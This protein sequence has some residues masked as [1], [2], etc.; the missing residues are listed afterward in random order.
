VFGPL[1]KSMEPGDGSALA[2][3]MRSALIC[4]SVAYLGDCGSLS[5]HRVD[6]L[7]MSGGS[8]RRSLRTSQHLLLRYDLL[9]GCSSIAYLSDCNSLSIHRIDGLVLSLRGCRQ[10]LYN[11]AGLVA[12]SSALCTLAV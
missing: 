6:G 5:I 9:Q 4:S 1:C 10:S 12:I 11:C 7:I 8:R 2:L 3:D